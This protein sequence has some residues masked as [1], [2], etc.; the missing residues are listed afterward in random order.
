[1][2]VVD[3]W[4][5]DGVNDIVFKQDN[6]GATSTRNWDSGW[7]GYLSQFVSG[8]SLSTTVTLAGADWTAAA[9]RFGASGGNSVTINDT[10][11]SNGGRINYLKL[12]DSSNVT[13]T[14]TRVDFMTG[15]D[16]I[17]NVT[18]GASNVKSVNLYGSDNTI[19]TGA[20][21]VGN[22]ETDGNTT[23]NVNG[24]VGSIFTG[25]GDD[26]HSVNSGFVEFLK[27]RG[28]DDSLDVTGGKVGSAKFNNSDGSIV[29]TTSGDGAI[30]FLTTNGDANI[31]MTGNSK[32]RRMALDEGVNVVDTGDG[33][34]QSI[35]SWMS[36]NTITVGDGGIGSIQLYG[37][38]SLAQKIVGNGSIESLRV[39]DGLKATVILKD[40]GAGTIRTDS[41]NDK[42][43][44][45]TGWVET[46]STGEGRDTIVVGTGGAGI[47]RAGGDNDIIKV[48]MLEG[49]GGFLVHGSSGTDTLDFGKFTTKVTFSLDAAGQWQNVSNPGDL[50][51]PVSGYFGEISIENLKG[52]KKNDHLTGDSNS[53]KLTGGKG[54][55]TLVGGEGNDMLIG[56]GGA[57]IFVFG[58][59][60]GTD[61]VKGYQAADTLQIEDH[62]GGFGSLTINNNKGDRVIT[63]DGGKIRLDGEAGLTLDASDFDFI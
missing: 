14:H 49:F 57:D 26:V 9:M 19:T 62:V 50:G 59:N 58:D 28:G 47:V 10:T 44:T 41:G 17:H 8:D 54:A 18:L 48:S 35:T 55:D 38:G 43:T 53:N 61:T 51:T 34:V 56:N 63:Y 21:W 16:G 4:T 3:S 27:S 52:G 23:V 20:G 31:S 32:I 39:H 42:V 13:L 2:P 40:G 22:I 11:S 7:M 45:G 46:I 24:D 33:F 5:V 36:K 37:D 6:A 25:S 12:G 29:V 1:M 30:N 60:G 15:G